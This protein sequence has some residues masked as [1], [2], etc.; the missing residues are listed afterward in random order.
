MII[1]TFALDGPEK[2]SGLPVARHSAESLSA[3]LA[4]DFDL[5][6]SRRHEHITPWQAVQKF[7]FSTFRYNL[8]N[9][10]R[11]TFMA[12]L[13]ALLR[14][15]AKVKSWWG[16]AY[17]APP[18]ARNSLLLIRPRGAAITLRPGNLGRDHKMSWGLPWSFAADRVAK[19]SAAFAF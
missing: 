13:A 10:F 1:G 19:C 3:L 18:P 12:A 5:I 16:M 14:Q 11:P 15:A 6:G 8:R 4:P 9:T 17:A 2:C 7:Q